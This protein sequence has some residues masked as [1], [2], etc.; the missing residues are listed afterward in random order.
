MPFLF[1]LTLSV[2]SEMTNSNWQELLWYLHSC[3]F[4]LT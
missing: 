3:Q 1:I 4:C 2:G